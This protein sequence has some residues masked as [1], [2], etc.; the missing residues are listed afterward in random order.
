MMNRLMTVAATAVVLGLGSV[1]GAATM[2]GDSVNVE[3]STVFLGSQGLQNSIVGA[4]SEGNYYSNQFYDFDDATDTFSISSTS[5][6]CGMTSCSP[7]DTVSWAL[8]SLDFGGPLTGVSIL[9]NGIGAT[10][11]SFTAD[12]VFF[13]WA[14]VGIP[15]GTYLTLKF[16]TAAV[17]LPA[18]LPLL[19]AGVAGLAALRRRR[20]SA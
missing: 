12:S 8:T 2:D 1:A 13:S 10:I 4:G 19:M 9:L 6:F 5:T 7:D 15:Q 11:S 3:M 17:P 16:E 20:K 14:N 18:S